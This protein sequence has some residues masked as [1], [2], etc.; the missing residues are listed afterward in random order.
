MS[1]NILIDAAVFAG[2]VIRGAFAVVSTLLRR[3]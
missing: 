1:G 3:R 2:I